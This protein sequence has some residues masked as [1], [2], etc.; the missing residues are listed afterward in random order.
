V[1]GEEVAH[2]REL[3]VDLVDPGALRRRSSLLRGLR[4]SENHAADAVLDM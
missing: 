4:G 1:H 3:S 2:L